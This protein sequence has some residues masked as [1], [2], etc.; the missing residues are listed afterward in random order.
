MCTVELPQYRKPIVY[1]NL[2]VEDL[3]D[4]DDPE[5]LFPMLESVA[6]VQGVGLFDYT[7]DYFQMP[8]QGRKFP[9]QLVASWGPKCLIRL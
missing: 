1:P 6:V 4:S 9:C 3:E 2:L 5:K 7:T 8:E